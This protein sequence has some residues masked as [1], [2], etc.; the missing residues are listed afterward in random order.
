MS[1]K[2]IMIRSKL[3][4]CS[5]RNKQTKQ[6]TQRYIFALFA[7]CL[8]LITNKQDWSGCNYFPCPNPPRFLFCVFFPPLPFLFSHSIDFSRAKS[9]APIRALMVRQHYCLDISY[10]NLF[11]PFSFSCS[12][13]TLMSLKDINSGKSCLNAVATFSDYHLVQQCYASQLGSLLYSF[14]ATQNYAIPYKIMQ[15]HTKNSICR[16][17]P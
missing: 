15:Y 6:E 10:N 16:N 3:K 5:A 17:V 12:A 8:L 14:N 11:P 13:F 9:E 1:F 2:K 7:F 4:Q